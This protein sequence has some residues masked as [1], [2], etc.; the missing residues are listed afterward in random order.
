MNSLPQETLS[1]PNLT[2]PTK[3]YLELSS[4]KTTTEQGL[5]MQQWWC[6]SDR[7]DHRN[8]AGVGGNGRQVRLRWR[9]K[10]ARSLIFGHGHG[11]GGSVGGPHPIRCFTQIRDCHFT[12]LSERF[13]RPCDSDLW[14]CMHCGLF[15][16]CLGFLGRLFWRFKLHYCCHT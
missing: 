7:E 1:R 3:R 11:G 10:R 13:L 5:C 8:G 9:S 2:N 4:H 12:G 6:D 14:G 15:Q 16:V